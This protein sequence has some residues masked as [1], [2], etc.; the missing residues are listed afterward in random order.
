MSIFKYPYRSFTPA[1][2]N[3]IL[4]ATPW[5][6]SETKAEIRSENELKVKG[7]IMNKLNYVFTK[8]RLSVFEELPEDDKASHSS[9]DAIVQLSLS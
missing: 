3:V 5:P 9:N 4:K 6:Q 1:E 2:P 7:G 8:R